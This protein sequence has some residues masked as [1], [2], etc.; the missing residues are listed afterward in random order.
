MSNFALFIAGL[1]IAFPIFYACGFYIFLASVGKKYKANTWVIF[2]FICSRVNRTNT[3]KSIGLA[4]ILGLGIY[5][6]LLS[7][8]EQGIA[9][10]ALILFDLILL[11]E[12]VIFSVKGQIRFNDFH[13][14]T[15]TNNFMD[16]QNSD[17]NHTDLE[18]TDWTRGYRPGGIYYEANEWMNK[19]RDL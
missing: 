15:I 14:V 10:K 5:L 19:M 18:E 7:D 12:T 2:K 11:L 6:V 9:V 13:H 3:I 1:L 4:I 16:T 17:S 8:M